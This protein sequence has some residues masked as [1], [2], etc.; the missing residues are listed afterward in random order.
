LWKTQELVKE[1]ETK[2][3]K[4]AKNLGLTNFNPNYEVFH[5]NRHEQHSNL[6]KTKL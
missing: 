4:I 1:I 6:W 2:H 3:R 5:D